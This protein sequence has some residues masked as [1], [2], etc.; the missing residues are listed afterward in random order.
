MPVASFG[1]EWHVVIDT[2]AGIDL[3]PRS[4]EAGESVDVPDR[5]ILVLSRRSSAAEAI[6]GRFGA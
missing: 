2:A 3:T 6:A 1:R 5:T 4:L